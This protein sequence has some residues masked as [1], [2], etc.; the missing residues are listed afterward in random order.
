MAGILPA[1]FLLYYIC[2]KDLS[3]LKMFKNKFI[4]LRRKPRVYP[5]ISKG[6][7]YPWMP[8]L[9]RGRVY[10]SEDMNAKIV[11]RPGFA[12]GYAEASEMSTKGQA[13]TCFGG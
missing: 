12:K 8:V 2:K 3:F 7:V 11:L 9:R 6:E 5:P 4:R 13:S 1:I 10:I